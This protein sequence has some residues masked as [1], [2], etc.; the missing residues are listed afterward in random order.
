VAPASVFAD[1]IVPACLFIKASLNSKVGLQTP[2]SWNIQLL[3]REVFFTT[4]HV[5][6]SNTSLVLLNPPKKVRLQ[7]S[8]QPSSRPTC[9]TA[10]ASL[11]GPYQSWNS[12]TA[13]QHR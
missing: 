9:L 10:M 4:T 7:S 13:Q 5:Q 6:H 3:L 2:K 1:I 12:P 8:H 11:P